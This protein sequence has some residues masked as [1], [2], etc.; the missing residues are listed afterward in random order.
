MN[1]GSIAFSEA[2]KKLQEQAGSRAG[3]ARMEKNQV[4]DSF[5]PYEREFIAQRDGFYLSTVGEN[6]FPYIQFRGGPMGFLKV[7]DSTR[8]AFVDFSGNKQFISTGNIATNNKVSLFL[9]DYASRTRLKILAV[10]ELLEIAANL[11]LL[12]KLSP[13]NYAFKPER[14]FVLHLKAFDWNCPQHITPRF[15]LQEIEAAFN[16]QQH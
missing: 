10:A 1:F 11:D 6:G 2:A 4:S 3:Y 14:I 8:L 9:M 12:E 5:T 13:A 16:S 7:L 15:T